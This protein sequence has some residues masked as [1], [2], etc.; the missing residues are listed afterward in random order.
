MSNFLLFTSK[1]LSMYFWMM[2]VD[3][4]IEGFWY[5][6]QE[7]CIDDWGTLLAASV[8]KDITTVDGAVFV[9]LSAIGVC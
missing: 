8:F 6:K 1:G 3:E 4:R 5:P 9:D 2:K 7:L